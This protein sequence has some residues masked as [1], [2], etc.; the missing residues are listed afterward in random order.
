[1]ISTE[2]DTRY[3]QKLLSN[4]EYSKALEY[5]KQAIQENPTEPRYH[6]NISNVYIVLN[7]IEKAKQHLHEALRLNPFQPEPYNNLG[8]LYYKQMLI[9][10]AMPFFERALR[11]NPD[12]WEA[13]YNL[14]H[15]FAKKNQLNRAITHYGEVVRL[16]PEHPNA[17]F[18]LGLACIEE[19]KF[20]TAALHLKR[21]FE[22]DPTNSEAIYQLGNVYVNLGKAFDA[23]A[24]F[25]QALVLV[26]TLEEAHHNLA[27]LH[28]RNQEKQKALSRFKEALSLNPGNATAKHMVSA[29][30]ASEQVQSAPLPYITQ[31]F[32][33]Y[34]D[35]YDTHVKTQLNYQAPGHLR[36]AVGRS[37]GNNLKTGRVL[38]MG[39]GTG[40]CGIY[41]RD[42]AFELIGID[43]SPN[44]IEK[45]KA[46]G[47]YE[48]LL[49]SDLKEYLSDSTLEKF[50]LIIAGDVFVYAGDLTDLFK[51]VSEKLTAEGRFAFT[52]E[53]L[54]TESDIYQ[55]QPT[56]R[57]AHSKNYITELTKRNDFTISIEE[58]IILREHE[59]T[60]IY[61]NVY[62]LLINKRY[63]NSTP[64]PIL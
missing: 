39:C 13:H 17:H 51:L 16:N 54:N 26:P 8:R 31:L 22:L 23:A 44:M 29:L 6:L 7:D 18:N 2:F 28:L 45:A 1:M 38:D 4:Q 24:A 5:F 58:N 35:Y 19:T 10:E 62:V 32:D 40:L 20:E 61:G 49:V 60:P 12:Y 55:L 36:N 56:G 48:Q 34:A 59:G 27:I 64:P 11:M 25:E 52:V 3:V 46:L 42:L 14:A 41:F 37:L 63:T 53:C 30:T 57:F 47:A 50:D 15:C 33:Q 43:L 21:A 9:D